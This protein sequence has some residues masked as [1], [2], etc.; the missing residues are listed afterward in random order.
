MKYFKTYE[1]YRL[2]VNGVGSLRNSLAALK[3]QNINGRYVDPEILA[4]AIRN[5]YEA[6]TGEKYEDEV[7]M[8]MD[9]TIADIIGHYKLDGPDFMAA[10]DKVVKESVVTEAFIGPFVFNDRMSDDELKAMYNGALD[11]YANY[12]KG[13]QHSKSDYKRAYQEIEKILKKRGVNVDESVV[14]EEKIK[15]A[16]GKTYQSS[17]H[18]TVMV[19]SNSSMC[20]IRVN[21]SAGWRLDPHDD[22]EETWELLDN[23]RQ[24]ATIYF[25][26]GNIDK[27]AKQMFDLND[28]TTW[29]NKTKLTAKDY[30][31]IIRVWIDMKKANESIINEASKDKMI[32][33]IERALKDGLSIFKLPMATQKYY[34]KN[35]G[36]FEVVAEKGYN[37]EDIYDLIAFHRFNTDFR[38][39]SSKNKEW[40]EN[41]AAERGFN[42][43]LL[44]SDI[45]D[46]YYSLIDELYEAKPGP[47]AYMTGLSDKEKEEKE[48]KMKKQA[49]MDDDDPDSYEELPGDEEAR[50]SGKVKK[51]KHTTAYNKK[52][53]SESMKNLKSFDN[54]VT[55]KRS[56]LWSPF[57]KADILAGD[58]F[59]AMGLYRLE[60]DE[61]DQIIDL[62]KADK[63]AKK[64]FGEFGF[65]TLAAKEMEDLLDNNPKLLRESQVNEFYFEND[66]EERLQKFV[67][68]LSFG[69]ELEYRDGFSTGRGS[70]PN[71][72]ELKKELDSNFQLLLTQKSG[73]NWDLYV[74][75]DDLV[76]I[77]QPDL[78]AKNY[79]QISISS[80][81]EQ[82]NDES[83]VFAR[84]NGYSV[85][86]SVVNE[87]GPMTGSGNRNY[88][89]NDLV[90]RIGDLDDI[91]M[92]DRKSE[93]EWEEMSQNYLDGEK[94]SEF[95][96]DLGDQ[97]LQDAINDAE[98][99]MKKYR[100]KESVVTEEVVYNSSNTKPEAAKKAT[101]EFGKLLPKPNKGVEPYEF[102]VVKTKR[103][104]YRLA[105]KSGSY[106]AH[107]FM[108]NLTDDGVLT[109]DIV[110]NAVS[111][112]IKMNPEEFNES[113][114]NN[115]SIFSDIVQD[116]EDFV[117]EKKSLNEA[118]R[119]KVHKA[120]KQGSYPA[121]I[122][123][124]Q[125]GKV[126]HQ[127]PVSTP[128]VAPATFNVMQEKYPKALLHLED[129]TGKRLFSEA[130]RIFLSKMDE[131]KQSDELA[132][133]INTA[134][135][136]I[137]DS[138]SYVDFAQAVGKVIRD[139]YG[140][141]L[142]KE[143]KKEINKSLKESVD[144]NR[145]LRKGQF[146]FGAK[147]QYGIE[148]VNESYGFYGT[149]LDQFGLDEVNEL[150]LDG[151]SVL[152][153]NYDFTD[154][155]ALYYLNSKA[156]RWVADQVVEKLIGP[157]NMSPYYGHLEEI[158]AEYAKKGQWKK[159]SKEYDQFAEEDN[160]EEGLMIRESR[161][162]RDEYYR[163][164]LE[165]EQ[166]TNDQS[167][168]GDD[169]ME[170]GINNKA[171]ESG[172]PVGLLRIIMRRGL[173]AWKTGHRPGATQAQWGYARVN[174]FLTKQP[175]TWGKAD[176]DIAKKVRDGGH[177]KDL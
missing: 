159:W 176:S 137:D 90:D 134:I 101:K 150:Y 39:L 135:E 78:G 17:G 22:R 26:S 156:G 153:T 112:I 148:D 116:F 124:V 21:H 7:Q 18:W 172:V 4:Q 3:R 42:E 144:E 154:Q 158:F 46:K 99:L 125:D 117:K 73:R 43:S 108:T 51:S 145:M 93:R 88:S 52:F 8:S 139:E 37:M 118:S 76:F 170:T 30:A 106:V 27:F 86:E 142:Y 53:K 23:G 162:D 127:E 59:G 173:A 113:M 171:K 167:P 41:D 16:K 57:Q 24:R 163:G 115:Q 155:A 132:I 70:F 130:K 91:L 119:R 44:E 149:L 60:D 104:N 107:E 9:N 152:G 140:T 48:A 67:D 5:E 84:S 141:H 81:K 34:S 133:A 10:W 19:D 128:D 63:L 15:Y 174:S 122:V 94:G 2:G 69:D 138:M 160:M 14:T 47:D 33:Q 49:E 110:K 55:E 58:M 92:S 31:D 161:S 62:K 102:A 50:E 6:I 29:G 168:L 71:T 65:K 64:M 61:L 147:L 177:D 54:F 96:G 100:I 97:E 169:G 129:K 66:E 123:V 79:M 95:W 77:I 143:F 111:N 40:V 38:K 136:K 157:K 126:I 75:S 98:S 36:D 80:T 114:V 164:L 175:G 13:F 121:V 25:R 103:R 120:A 83:S 74:G 45:V 87:F 146:R 72:R 28:R 109:A 131:S 35:K 89:T 32:R 56:D 68:Q 20:D 166:T 105:I 151:F 1:A 85:Y 82:W 165:A 11:G 12:S